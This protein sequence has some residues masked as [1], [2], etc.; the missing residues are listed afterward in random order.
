[1][2]AHRV[3]GEDDS[4]NW[5]KEKIET[6]LRLT[7]T[8]I[9]HNGR[10]GDDLAYESSASSGSVYSS[11]A[12]ELDEKEA[13]YEDRCFYEKIVS[14]VQNIHGGR[15]VVCQYDYVDAVHVIRTTK[16]GDSQASAPS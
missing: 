14:G 4:P 10:D 9:P 16:S 8:D 3:D 13:D 11:E 2:S 12:D 5:T 6:W 7:S 1:M 15:C